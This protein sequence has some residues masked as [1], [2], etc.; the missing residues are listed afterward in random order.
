MSFAGEP[1]A[2]R[3]GN[4]RPDRRAVHAGEADRQ[5]LGIGRA[6]LP[7]RPWQNYG[8]LTDDDLRALFAYLQSLKAGREHGSAADSAGERAGS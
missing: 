1:N 2:P 5:A 8:G 6:I 4:A 3:N 7:P